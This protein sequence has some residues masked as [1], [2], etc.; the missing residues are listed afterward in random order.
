MADSVFDSSP[1]PAPAQVSAGPEDHALERGPEADFGAL[2]D[3][4]CR[5]TAVL[6]ERDFSQWLVMWGPYSREFWAY[7]L[8]NAPWGTIAQSALG[9]PACGH[10]AKSCARQGGVLGEVLWAAAVK[11]AVSASSHG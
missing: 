9:V 1:I 11:A 6:I 8:F 2:P 7:P 10:C 3:S 4:F 5:R